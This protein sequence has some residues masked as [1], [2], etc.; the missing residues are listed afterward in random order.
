MN[1]PKIQNEQPRIIGSSR[2]RYDFHAILIL[3]KIIHWDDWSP[4]RNTVL[5]LSPTV[6]IDCR[7]DPKPEPE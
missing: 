4:P 6:L 7:I 1:H 2:M 3:L 5:V